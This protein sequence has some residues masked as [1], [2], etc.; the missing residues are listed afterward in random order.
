MLTLYSILTSLSAPFLN[1]LLWHRLKKGKENAARISER[2]GITNKL[3]PDGKL[4][5]I[6]A[7][8]VGETQSALILINKLL[9]ANESL[10][11]LITS[12]TLTSAQLM[13]QRLPERAI[14][15]FVPL[16]HPKWVK[17]FL[18][19]WKP[20]AAIWIES[21]LWPNMLRQIK[22]RRIPAALINA[23]L[24][25]TSF[26]RW[27]T[28][29]NTAEKILSCF[30][31][32]LTQ[33]ARDQHYFE[34]LKAEKVI[35]AGNIKHSAEALPYDETAYHALS[36][37]INDRPTWV[38]SST[39]DGEEELAGTVHKALKQNHPDLLTIIVP[40]HP[41]RRDDIRSKIDGLTLITRH[42]NAT[43]PEADTDIYLADTLGELGLFYKICPIA[44][45][46]RSFSHDGGGGHN[47]LEAAQ[48]GCA[49]LTGPNFQYQQ[50]L[51]NDMID[52]DAATIVK[53]K[54]D[55][56]ET[57]DTLLSN[58]DFL[59]TMQNNALTY[60]G[61]QSHLVD[62]I[63]DHLTPVLKKVL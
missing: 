62:E 37:A 47:P 46:G 38:F 42:P 26:R 54:D 5:W 27:F 35:N 60:A 33:T 13:Q 15:Q 58:H 44:M 19:H 1:I 22:K 7:A 11:I 48:L 34:K 24:S 61:E 40:R 55:F 12:G 39:H 16:D 32:I 8:S 21:E 53:T 36:K 20:N 57:L 51:F 59:K 28:F 45:I 6:H 3:R 9:N 52:A 56:I 17:G 2:R 49:V 29:K 14:H 25:Q 18:K 63:V 50:D 4:I 10:N 23:R 31:V 30:K 41:E 43:L